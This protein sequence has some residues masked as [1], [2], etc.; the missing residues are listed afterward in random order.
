MFDH[1]QGS[2]A[3]DLYSFKFREVIQMLFKDVTDHERLYLT[4]YALPGWECMFGPD[5]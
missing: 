1:S 2:Y 3:S 5:L 4:V